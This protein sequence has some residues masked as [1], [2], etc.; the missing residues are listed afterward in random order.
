MIIYFADRQLNISGHASTKLLGGYKITEDTLTEDVESGVNTLSLNVFVNDGDRAELESMARVGMFVLCSGGRAFDDKENQYN[1]L[2]QIIETEYNTL[3]RELSIY[4]EDA[5]LELINKVCPASEQ[6]N[7]TLKQMLEVFVPSDWTINLIGTPTGTKTN[8]W[9]GEN[10][11]TER[12][13]SVASLFDCEV[14]YS[15]VIERLAITSKVI[16]VIPKRGSQTAVA[17]LR[18]D[19]NINSITTKTSITDLA[20]A[21]SVTGS[22]D[23]AVTLKNY[24]YSYTDPETGDEY[25]VDKATGQMRNT[26]AMKRWAS[27]LDNDGLIV[28]SFSF[29]TSDKAILAGQARA[30]LQKA[31][32]ETVQYEVD[33]AFLPEDIQVGDRINIIDEEGEVYLEARVLKLESS[34]VTGNQSATLGEYVLKESGIDAAVAQLAAQLAAEARTRLYTIEI[35]SSEGNVFSDTLV[36]T[37][38]TAEVFLNGTQVSDSEVSSVGVIRWY[39]SENLEA[40]LGTG[41][42]LTITE[43]QNFESVNIIARLEVD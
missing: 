6:K 1:S 43:D 4:A 25:S 28:K 31:S 14:Y 11:A 7:K 42:T 20:T 35:T 17:Q 36:S 30:E 26:S 32:K 33:F 41:K 15:F 16:N 37:T 2:Y 18:L 38:L 5:G 13:N 34:A 23:P 8:K 3:T 21:Y 27:S 10:T 19:K 24:N 12:I 9:D 40:I 39:N 22:G 29:D